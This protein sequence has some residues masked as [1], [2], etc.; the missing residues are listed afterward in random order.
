MN[1]KK[2]KI[3]RRIKSSDIPFKILKLPGNT[4]Y[5]RKHILSKN[6]RLL[7]I[8]PTFYIKKRKVYLNK[9]NLNLLKSLNISVKYEKYYNLKNNV[10][11]S[12]IK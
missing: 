11:S 7:I 9:T 3:N 4:V 5:I 2:F 6:K 1:N 10:E 8:N 12:K